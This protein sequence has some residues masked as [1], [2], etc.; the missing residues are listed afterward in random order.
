METLT[1]YDSFRASLLILLEQ[2][3]LNQN[4]VRDT[5]TT[6]PN[7]FNL[8]DEIAELRPKITICD[9]H[10]S[11]DFCYAWESCDD[12]HICP[13][14]VMGDCKDDSCSLGHCW[15][16]D[17]NRKILQSFNMDRLPSEILCTLIRGTFNERTPTKSLDVCQS[18][19]KGT[20]K[21]RQCSSLH[22]CLNFVIQ[23]GICG[24]QS[25]QLN[26]YTTE[27]SV[28]KLLERH[29]LPSNRCS[30]DII[31]TLLAQNQ[32]LSS[33]AYTLRR[34]KRSST[35][36]SIN[37]PSPNLQRGTSN[38]VWSHFYKGDVPVPEIC[39]SS[40]EGKCQSE[41]QGCSRLHAKEHFHWQV[42]E[43]SEQWFNLQNSQVISLER[44]YCDPAQESVTIPRLDTA[45]VTPTNPLLSL[46]G[47]DLWSAD[48]VNQ[49]LKDSSGEKIL[50]LRR[51]CTEKT[52]MNVPAS[53]FLWYYFYD[54]NWVKYGCRNPSA[55][56]DLVYDVSS[57]SIEVAYNTPDCQEMPLKENNKIDFQ[58]MV[59]INRLSHKWP[60][61]RRPK[62]HLEEAKTGIEHNKNLPSHWEVMNPEDRLR[63]VDLPPWCTEYEQVL[64]LLH[65]SLQDVKVLKVE[66]VQNP[67]LWR[68][69]QNKI[70]ELSLWYGDTEK[71]DVRTLFH[72]T[73]VDVIKH[74]CTENFDWRLHGSRFGQKYGHGAYFATDAA[75]ALEY[76]TYD[77]LNQ[78]YLLVAQAVVGTIVQGDYSMHCPPQ[79]PVTGIPYNS[80][81]DDEFEPTII[82]KYDK[83]EYYPQYIITLS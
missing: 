39:Y 13:R 72:G 20:C 36:S 22:I 7:T 73:D 57:E 5:I 61:R 44:A 18:Y 77:P 30:K 37:T 26:H 50:N 16:T 45:L 42:S 15:T 59:H 8:S 29:G 53:T 47:R 9:A 49:N 55:E 54:G 6:Y 10:I 38:T 2:H 31:A 11:H 17:H 74:I 34:V 62:S 79:N 46:L 23:G 19:N 51:L 12:L 56:A 67:F 68:A 24:L 70:E 1:K 76:C 60:I 71:V 80:T 48:L 4:A 58:G 32:S 28:C 65:T 21:R 43:S 81:V 69:L 3:G 63:I 82:V 78:R 25:C 41:A 52:E 64:E 14:Y 35:A 33:Q 66:R 83:Q 75:K 27:P 40:V